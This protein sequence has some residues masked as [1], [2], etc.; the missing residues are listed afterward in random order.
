[1]A[2]PTQQAGLEQGALGDTQPLPEVQ[3]RNCSPPEGA[4]LSQAPATC[5]SKLFGCFCS[6]KSRESSVCKGS[7]RSQSTS[8]PVLSS[9]RV[10]SLK[11]AQGHGLLPI[12]ATPPRRHYLASYHHRCSTAMETKTRRLK[13]LCGRDRD[14][15]LTLLL[16]CLHGKQ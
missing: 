2:Q 15:A 8:N 1:M 3:E 11:T 10:T 5:C 14:A 12:C 6:A 13:G 4:V 7:S 9:A 16:S